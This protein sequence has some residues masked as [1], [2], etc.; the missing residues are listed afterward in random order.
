MEENASKGIMSTI[1]IVQEKIVMVQF[2]VRFVCSVQIVN[3]VT[4]ML[5]IENK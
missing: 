2:F 1:I 3:L 4:D 5:K